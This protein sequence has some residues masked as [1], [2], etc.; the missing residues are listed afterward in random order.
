MK[1]LFVSY[2]DVKVCQRKLRNPV[3]VKGVS[4][5]H[6]L[7]F[8]QDELWMRETS[9]YDQCCLAEPVCP[10][11]INTGVK[12]QKTA[13]TEAVQEENGHYTR[14]QIPEPEAVDQNR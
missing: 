1:P 6:T 10:G 8:F 12:F 2:N 11:W 14:Q 4:L 9:C 7:R 5:I 13:A 3:P